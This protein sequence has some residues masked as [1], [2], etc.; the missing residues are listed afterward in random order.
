[1]KE[2][3][4]SSPTREGKDVPLLI[5]E[6]CY[7]ISLVSFPTLSHCDSMKLST[8]FFSKHSIY[9]MENFLGGFVFYIVLLFFYHPRAF[10]LNF[11]KIGIDISFAKIFYSVT[12]KFLQSLKCYL[13]WVGFTFHH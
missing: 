4:N 13:L 3:S 2:S 9:S 11:F 8:C 1:M 6:L 7:R 5:R 12:K 10:N